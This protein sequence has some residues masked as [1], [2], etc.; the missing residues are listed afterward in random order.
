MT[1]AASYTAHVFYTVIPDVNGP[2]PEDKIALLPR[3]FKD[4][5]DSYLKQDDKVRLL[6]GKLLLRTAL[7]FFNADLTLLEAYAA[8]QNGRPFISGFHDFNITHSGHV[9][10]CAVIPGA[11]AGIDAEMIRAIQP[12]KFTKQFS[13]PEMEAI[14]NADDPHH[15]FFDFWTQKEAVMKADGRGMRIPLHDIR[16]LGDYATIEGIAHPWHLYP[17]ALDARHKAHLCSPEKINDIRLHFTD[18]LKG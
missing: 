12:E 11:V 4:E 18:V 2:L 14:L 1:S 13:R 16:L 6:A 9:V 7:D 3:K 10:A 8:D 17:L 5:I 15:C